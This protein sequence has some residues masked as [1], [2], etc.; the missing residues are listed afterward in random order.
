MFSCRKMYRS[1]E[2]DELSIGQIL[3][4]LIVNDMD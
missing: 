3:A 4:V 2:L 1:L